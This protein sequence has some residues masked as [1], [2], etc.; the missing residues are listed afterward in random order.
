MKLPALY[1]LDCICKN[2]KEIY[3]PLFHKSLPLVS[4]H[5]RSSTP[6]AVARFPRPRPRQPRTR[7]LEALH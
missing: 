5:G 1:L 6:R 7:T 4:A 2:H 3:A